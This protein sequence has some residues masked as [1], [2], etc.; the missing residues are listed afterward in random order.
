MAPLPRIDMIR[1]GANIAA[2]RCRAGLSVRQ[3]QAIFGFSTPQA[4]YK[5][6]RGDALPSLD[7]LLVLGELFGVPVEEIIICIRPEM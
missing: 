4:I 7:N 5:W 3:L 6:Q 2:L 1:T